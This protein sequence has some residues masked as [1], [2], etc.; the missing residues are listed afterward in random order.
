MTRMLL[1]LALVAVAL[2]SCVTQTPEARIKKQPAAFLALPAKHQE[3]VRRGEIARGMSP[4]AVRLAWGNPSRRF[5]GAK[6]GKNIERW[7]YLGSQPV[8]TN[9]M[10]FGY[11]NPWMWGPGGWG[12]GWQ[13]FM[14]P[15][16][17][18]IPYQRASIV[19]KNQLVDSWEKLQEDQR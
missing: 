3:L 10:G 4:D 5:S 12:G 7:D 18:Y 9:Q 14:G 15:D 8:F 6:E 1:P 13:P 19:F 11:G 17:A 16:V 2:S